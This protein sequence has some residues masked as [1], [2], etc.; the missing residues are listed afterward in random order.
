MRYQWRRLIELGK[1]EEGHEMLEYALL[2][3]FI[4]MP[5]THIVPFLVDMLRAYY[6]LLSFTLSLPF[7]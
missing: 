7:P 1:N 4:I 3:T 2:A 6:E 5:L